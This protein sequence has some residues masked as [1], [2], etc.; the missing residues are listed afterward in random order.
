MKLFDL[1]ATI[2]LD[3]K[4]VKSEIA[5]VS[6]LLKKFSGDIGDIGS[7]ITSGLGSV[8]TAV[9]S[10]LGEGLTMGAKAGFM[11]ANSLEQT[12]ANFSTFLG[13]TEKAKSLMGDI[14]DLAKS[15]PFEL[16]ELN[17]SAQMLLNYG[18]SLEEVIPDMKRLGD[19]AMGDKEKLGGLTMAFGQVRGNGR[20]MGEELNQM[21]ERGF[22]PLNNISKRTGKSI[23]DLRDEMGDGLISFDM[24]RQAMIDAT[25]AGGQFYGSMDKSS[26]TLQGQWSTLKDNTVMVLGKIMTPLF[27]YLSQTVLP[28]FNNAFQN[29][30]DL[31]ERKLTML[32][33][34][35]I[36]VFNSIKNIIKQIMP[37]IEGQFGNFSNVI[38]PTILASLMLFFDWIERNMPL[39]RNIL[40][41]IISRI[42]ELVTNI[43][44]LVVNYMPLISVALGIA[45]IAFDS[46]NA[47]LGFIADN[48]NILIPIMASL[49]TA[50]VAFK[51]IQTISTMLTA[52]NILMTAYR[53][54]T[55]LA[56]LAQMGLNL[57]MF[58]NPIGL[59]ILAISALVGIII[60]LYNNLDGA[61]KVF[62]TFG[63]RFLDVMN[64]VKNAALTSLKGIFFPLIVSWNV[65]A[66]ALSLINFTVPS[67]V[68][69]IGGNKITGPK[70]PTI[71]LLAEG[72]IIKRGGSAIV[73]EAGAEL[74]N[75]PRGASVTPLSKTGGITINIVEPKIFKTSDIDDLMNTITRRLKI[76]NVGR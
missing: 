41:E 2:S 38:V 9:L 24:V 31:V 60:Y 30:G 11:F 22:N 48:A 74:I 25:S 36:D 56:T 54:G 8:S 33:L 67:W 64:F 75:L 23:A 61:K 62:D 39:I 70:L 69:G 32:K 42:S 27:N 49:L 50:F 1:L 14:Q 5:I 37:V 35:F 20:L 57:A 18:D 15:T 29:S 7:S 10:R 66:K 21:I 52:L 4:Q 13:S 26:K 16:P 65:L 17:K 46:F 55:L 34:V 53:A 12:E 71:P 59:V 51:V 19:I 28:F 43:I 47:V 72:G 45:L 76:A 40:G 63:S 44:N 73:G 6:K 68:P 58:A 3:S